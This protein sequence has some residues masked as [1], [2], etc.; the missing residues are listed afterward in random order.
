MLLANLFVYVREYAPWLILSFIAVY[1][2]NNKFCQGINHIPGPWLAGFSDVWRL[3]LVWGRRPEVAHRL[4]HAKYGPLV[5]IGP[6]TVIVG[7]PNA[8]KTIYALNAGFVKSG[9]YPVQ[10]TVANGRELHSMFNTTDEVFHAKLRRAVSNAYAMST[11]VKFEPL[12]DST[13]EAF[14]KQLKQ[15]FADRQDDSGICDLGTWLQYYAF[16]V[17]GELTFSARIGFVDRG[18]DVD[19]IIGDLEWLLNYVAVVG[20]IPWLDRLLLKNPV[21]MLF[22]KY[23]LFKATSSVAVFARQRMSERQMKPAED[24]TLSS[25]DFLSRFMDANKKDPTFIS[26]DRVLALT[27]ANCFAGSDTTAITLRAVFYYLLKNPKSM[28]KLLAEISEFE[29][30]VSWEQSRDLPYLSS[31][32]KEALRIH[33]AVGLP[34]ERIVPAGGISVC[35]TF[36]PGGTIIGCSAWVVHKDQRVFG[37]D[38]D[39]WRPERWL[40]GGAEKQSLMNSMLFSF[41]AGSRTCIGKNI[42]LLEMHKLVPTLLKTFKLELVGS[43]QS[44]TLHNAWFVK[45]NDFRVRLKELRQ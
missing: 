41:G 39:Q 31:V 15:R 43:E 28:E 8:I 42:S 26:K 12:V 21:R 36:I 7:D 2:V 14:V 33:P 10:M 9:F 27:V 38:A 22:S 32:I 35:D 25:K 40:E 29:G 24:S 5:R 23:N 13:T 17:I 30:L 20:Q 16:D 34:L 1:L 11:L 6:R 18:L 37:E 4:L 19:S 44:W 45:Q 3:L